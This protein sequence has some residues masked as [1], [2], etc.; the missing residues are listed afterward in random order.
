MFGRQWT[1]RLFR[2]AGIDVFL[3]WSWFVVAVYEVQSTGRRYSSLG[4]SVGE[5]L[6]LFAIVGLHEFGHAL[7]CR[8]TGGTVQEIILWPLGGLAYV[9]PPPRPAA[10]LW[11]LA[12]GPLVNL[13]L[14]PL[15]LLLR[16]GGGV[17]GASGDLQTLF[18]TLS[19]MNMGLLIFN[20]L[21]IYPLDGGQILRSLLWFV[22]GRG[23]SLV[24]A[25]TLGFAGTLG[26]LALAIRIES[27]WTAVVALFAGLNCWRG[28][29]HARALLRLGRLPRRAGLRCPACG[30]P[31]PVGPLWTCSRCRTAFDT[32]ETG[33]VCPTCGERFART[34]CPECG[35]QHPA[36]AW[37]APPPPL[38]GAP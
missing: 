13:L 14:V 21:P 25:T 12:A 33:A 35:A 2:L 5:Y 20:L 1:V 37:A 19:Y 32:F 29:Q 7:A 28:L 16:T 30:T 38:G 10:T 22:L 31:P 15:F 17:P 36:G 9:K 8:Q 23:R 34:T 26:L 11:S 27:G 18:T 6:A 4:W 24:V 3:H